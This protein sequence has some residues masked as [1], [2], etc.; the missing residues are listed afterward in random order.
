M[1]PKPKASSFRNLVLLP[2][3][4]GIEAIV[5]KAMGYAKAK[6][7]GAL[8]DAASKREEGVGKIINDAL[9]AAGLMG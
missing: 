8:S 1:S 6:L 7:G 2:L 5:E 4:E 3:P 9:R